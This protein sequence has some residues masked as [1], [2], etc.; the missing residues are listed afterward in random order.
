MNWG[1]T[2]WKEEPLKPKPFSPV[3]SARK[4]SA[5]VLFFFQVK[6]TVT[7]E[8]DDRVSRRASKENGGAWEERR[9]GRVVVE[10]G[11]PSRQTTARR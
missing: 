8:R 3:H 7:M 2:R 1:I 9:Q 6:D 5:E 10:R 11:I 4:F